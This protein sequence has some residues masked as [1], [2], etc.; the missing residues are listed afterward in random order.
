MLEMIIS[1]SINDEQWLFSMRVPGRQGIS[2]LGPEHAVINHK[3]AGITLQ[4]AFLKL[5]ENTAQTGL[6]NL[7]TLKVTFMVCLF[8]DSH[9]SRD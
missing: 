3:M 2:G 8:P 1:H 4:T 5:P 6:M 7:P 9:Q